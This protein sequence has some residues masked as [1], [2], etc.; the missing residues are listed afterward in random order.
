MQG[1]MKWPPKPNNWSAVVVMELYTYV[2]KMRK[3]GLYTSAIAWTVLMLLL[4]Q[5]G[6]ITARKSLNSKYHTTLTT[7]FV[8]NI[9][10]QLHCSE[11]TYARLYSVVLWTLQSDSWTQ[12]HAVEKMRL[13]CGR[14]P[15]ESTS[16]LLGKVEEKS[17]R[18]IHSCAPSTYCIPERTSIVQ[19]HTHLYTF[20]IVGLYDLMAHT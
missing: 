1:C 14:S 17:T 7:L 10:N 15:S 8:A 4:T 2:S 9:K 11:C 13:L 6:G 18:P 19:C 12:V 16:Q 3:M 5:N 20:H